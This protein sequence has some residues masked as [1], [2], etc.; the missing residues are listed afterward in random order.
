MDKQIT[1]KKPHAVARSSKAKVTLA[2]SSLVAL[3]GLGSF[4]FWGY[5]HLALLGLVGGSVI[6]LGS[7]L[8]H[9]IKSG[10]YLPQKSQKGLRQK[11]ISLKFKLDESYAE[12]LEQAITAEQKIQKKREFLDKVL[13]KFFTPSEMTYIRYHNAGQSALVAIEGNLNSIV[14]KLESVQHFENEENKQKLI[15]K[16][17]AIMLEIQALF[18]SYETLIMSFEECEQPQ[19]RDEIFMQLEELAK[20]TKKYNI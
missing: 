12:L 3:A 5:S 19:Q 7:Y 17:E 8:Y 20:R 14:E 10:A 11:L 9:H 16:I 2:T 6:S 1:T 18:E 15:Q 4:I 13:K